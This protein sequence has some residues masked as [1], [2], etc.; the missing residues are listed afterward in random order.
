MASPPSLCEESTYRSIYESYSKGLFRFLYYSYGDEEKSQDI[1]QEV[2]VKLWEKCN[3]YNLANI[4]SLIY[5]IGKN[6]MLN[7][8]QK[9]KVRLHYQ[10]ENVS[11]ES[12]PSPEFELEE[13]EFRL[14]LENAINQ[15]T[16]N[17]REVFLLSRIDQLTYSEIAE[18]LKLSQKAVEKRMH[19]ALQ[20]LQ[21]ELKISL[22]RK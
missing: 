6:L 16:V 5:T 3:E 11:F 2:F 20:K 19:G 7:E 17:E 14:E 4:K 12:A 21:A 22:R 9:S 13:N 18:R 8:L 10:N 15:L 1:T